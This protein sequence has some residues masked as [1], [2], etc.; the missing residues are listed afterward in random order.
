M[1]DPDRISPA[2]APQTAHILLTEAETNWITGQ[3]VKLPFENVAPIINLLGQK[4]M[5]LRQ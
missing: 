5:A 1:T 4:L 3:L 2:P